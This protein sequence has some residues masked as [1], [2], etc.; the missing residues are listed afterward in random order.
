MAALAILVALRAT[1][2]T[3][4]LH[5]QSFDAGAFA[6]PHVDFVGHPQSGLGSTAAAAASVNR[7]EKQYDRGK[8]G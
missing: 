3:F 4:K 7:S 1:Y 5:G 2:A 8:W 6:D